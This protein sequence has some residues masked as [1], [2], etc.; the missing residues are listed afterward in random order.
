MR[1]R[2]ARRAPPTPATQCGA[3][4]VQPAAL[5]GQARRTHEPAPRSRGA[6]GA[7]SA[8]RSRRALHSPRRRRR[9][10]LAPWRP[11]RTREGEPPAAGARRSRRARGGA[12][13]RRPPRPL[14]PPAGAPGPA[15][16]RGRSGSHRGRRLRPPRSRHEGGEAR[17]AG[18]TPAPLRPVHR[19]LTSLTRKNRFLERVR[20]RPVQLLDPC[21]VSE[22]AAG[23]RDQ[24]RL[25][26]TPARERLGPLL[27]AARFERLLAGRDHAAVDDTCEERRDLSGSDGDHGLVEDLEPLVHPTQLDQR[28]AR[29]I[30]HRRKEIVVAESLGDLRRLGSGAVRSVC[31][32]GRQALDGDRQQQIARNDRILPSLARQTLGSPKPPHRRPHLAGDR[33]VQPEEDRCL[34]SRLRLAGVEPELVEAFEQRVMG[35]ALADERR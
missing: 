11:R 7:R 29:G 9:P 26:F 24:L 10:D 5:R 6:S 8:R 33:E 19:L 28:R 34:G 14:V 32:A 13:R 20:P 1:P 4:A 18:S 30:R 21:A 12:R 27:R 23:E 3:S 25:R 15:A 31:V 17:P 22:T 2:T 35:V 16:A